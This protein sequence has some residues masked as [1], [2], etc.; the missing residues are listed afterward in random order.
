[1][2]DRQSRTRALPDRAG[3]SSRSE[4]PGPRSRAENAAGKAP[5]VR[6]RCWPRWGGLARSPGHTLNVLVGVNP[7]GGLGA[8]DRT[9]SRR[10]PGRQRPQGRA[11]HAAFRR[12][13]DPARRPDL[14]GRRPPGP[15]DRHHAHTGGNDAAGRRSSPL[16]TREMT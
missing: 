5:W 1:M 15:D 9:G 14:A 6:L 3:H 7:R 13:D 16:L 4:R 11:V 10:I 8:E 12:R 2:P